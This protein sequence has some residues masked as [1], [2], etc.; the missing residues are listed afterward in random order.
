MLILDNAGPLP[1][2]IAGIL[3]YSYNQY[4]SVFLIY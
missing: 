2:D 3:V 4:V 1:F